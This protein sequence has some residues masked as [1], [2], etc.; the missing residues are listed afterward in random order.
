[1]KNKQL[2][3]LIIFAIMLSSC[4]DKLNLSSL[5][6]KY[7]GF[8]YHIPPGETKTVKSQAE[9]NV[10]LRGTDFSAGKAPDRI[11]AGGSGK[12]TILNQKEVE[13]KDNNIWTADFDWN[14]VL[15][16]RYKYEHVN[17]SLILTRKFESCTTCEIKPG[18]MPGSYQYRLKRV[19]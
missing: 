11:P 18:M 9:I 2:P 8:F 3:L 16:G 7:A 10:D 6:G 13:F 17:D 14:L 19:N 4:S 1:M 5:E 12:F 15:N